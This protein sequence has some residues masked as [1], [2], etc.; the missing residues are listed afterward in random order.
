MTSS[1]RRRGPLTYAGD[2]LR[3]AA[4]IAAVHAHLFAGPLR[5]TRLEGGRDDTEVRFP[6]PEVAVVLGGGAPG[7]PSVQTFVL[8]RDGTG[9]R[10]TAFQNVRREG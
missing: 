10:V 2:V 5:G 9:W 1:R 4:E 7:R 6:H 8:V 3:G